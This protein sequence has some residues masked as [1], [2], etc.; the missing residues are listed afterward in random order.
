MCAS[1]NQPTALPRP[2]LRGNQDIHVTLA[3]M[4]GV[5]RGWYR[6]TNHE[7][8]GCNTIGSFRSNNHINAASDLGN[9]CNRPYNVICMQ[10]PSMNKQAAGRREKKNNVAQVQDW[11]NGT[12]IRNCQLKQAVNGKWPLCRNR[13]Y[14][15]GSGYT[16]IWRLTFIFNTVNQW[17][18]PP[19]DL[20]TEG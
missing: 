8:S 5:P 16:C 10:N 4:V 19:K 17:L 14:K 13:G 2:F 7:N 6:F 9:E 1:C 11:E 20:C 12:A 3:T 15:L 18:E